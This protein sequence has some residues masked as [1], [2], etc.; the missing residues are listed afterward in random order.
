MEFG[1]FC[2]LGP[3]FCVSER[4]FGFGLFLLISG[5]SGFCSRCSTFWD[6]L[7]ISG[8]FFHVLGLF[9]PYF[10]LHFYCGLLFLLLWSLCFYFGLFNLHFGVTFFMSSFLFFVL[11][12]FLFYLV[13]FFSLGSFFCVLVFIFYF[14]LCFGPLL[15]RFGPLSPRFR[16][17]HLSPPRP[18]LSLLPAPQATRPP[19]WAAP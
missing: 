16:P 8:P 13:Y 3:V 9:L 6:F 2:V 11:D 19:T 1:G 12:S 4:L 7:I 18:P 14:G 17:P 5:G 15:P 10:G